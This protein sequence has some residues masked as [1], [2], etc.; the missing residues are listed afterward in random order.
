[1]N[2]NPLK[3]EK[4]HKLKTGRRLGSK[5]NKI[6]IRQVSLGLEEPIYDKIEEMVS[7]DGKKSLKSIINDTLRKHL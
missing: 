7:K 2:N 6:K 3:L 4:K 1:M 5:N